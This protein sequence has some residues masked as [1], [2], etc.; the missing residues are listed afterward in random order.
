MIKHEGEFI[1]PLEQQS[2]E[3]GNPESNPTR[4][5]HASHGSAIQDVIRSTLENQENI[6]AGSWQA[7]VPQQERMGHIFNLSVTAY[8]N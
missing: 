3:E 5:S 7:S 6:L 1:E 8:S 2:T 4:S